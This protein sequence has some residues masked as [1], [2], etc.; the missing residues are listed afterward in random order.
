[1]ASEG[2]PV[3]DARA[4]S[5]TENHVQETSIEAPQETIVEDLKQ[6]EIKGVEAKG[7]A[8]ETASQKGGEGNV[9]VETEDKTNQTK[10]SA[11]HHSEEED[12]GVYEEVRIEDMDYDE[13]EDMFTYQCPCGDLFF[14]YTEDLENG[15]DI[16]HCPSCSLVIKVLY[17]PDDFQ[18]GEEV[19]LGG[20]GGGNAAK[21]DASRS[22]A[23]VLVR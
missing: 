1:M 6:L 11:D 13:D 21:E 17:N 2:A 20:C 15:E 18:G 3:S 19:E 10:G 5:S 4:E 9:P 23:G 7:N 14:I 8:G 12:E 16:A 22:S